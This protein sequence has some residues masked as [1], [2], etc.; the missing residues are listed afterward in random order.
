MKYLLLLSVFFTFNLLATNDDVLSIIRS[1]VIKTEKNL[2]NL[3]Y[4]IHNQDCEHRTTIK[5]CYFELNQLYNR[6]QAYALELNS[7]FLYKDLL[8]DYNKA[9]KALNA[10]EKNKNTYTQKENLLQLIDSK[11]KL[12]QKYPH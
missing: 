10:I 9:F 5:Q 3:K 11:L 1:N 2:L 12:I 6:L 4:K 7:V 8:I